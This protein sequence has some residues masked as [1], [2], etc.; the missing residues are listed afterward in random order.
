LRQHVRIEGG[1]RD[2]GRQ[3]GETARAL[4]ARSIEV[5]R[6]F[7]H[8]FGGWDWD[9][10]RAVASQFRPAIADLDQ[11][12]LHEIAGIA[13]GAEV[14]EDDVL[15]INVR[16]EVL[17]T[18]RARAAMNAVNAPH[19]CSAFGVLPSRTSNGHTLMAQNWDFFTRAGES[20]IILEVHQDDG[21]DYVTMVEAGLLAKVGMNSSGVAVLTNALVT[22]ADRGDIGV[23]YHIL[24]RAILDSET[25]SDA[26]GVL[27][28]RRRA[29]SANFILGHADGSII[30]FETAPGDYAQ[31]FALYPDHGLVLHT[32]HFASPAFTG[33]DVSLWSLPHSPFRL[34]RLREV[35]SVDTF[36]SVQSAKDALSDHVNYPMS[37]CCHPD[38]RV[39]EIEQGGTL[40][41]IIMD[42]NDRRMWV[43]DGAPCGAEYVELDYGEFLAKPSPLREAAGG[44]AQ[45]AP[46][47]RA[48]PGG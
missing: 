15:A 16:T 45:R 42:L 29:S 47:L 41:S 10:V 38:V 34:E 24:L 25:V 12:Y 28:S 35:L 17:S 3:Y 36:L 31:V 32:N 44:P 18:A 20:T 7:F 11:R 8:H 48:E 46:A 4:I 23:P 13:E 1:A 21:P 6:E 9:T 2:R 26:L 30:D 14:H 19:E 33:R 40:A 39:G 22:E 37:I 5:Y 27:L 43:A